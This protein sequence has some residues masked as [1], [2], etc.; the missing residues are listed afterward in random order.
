MHKLIIIDGNA[1]FHRA[2]HSMPPFH[3]S[4]GEVTNAIYGFLRMFFDLLKREKPEYV[5]VA[6]DRA[7]PT[8]RHEQYVEYKATRSAPPDDLYPQL[9][10]LKQILETMNITSFELDGFEA[11]DLIGTLT[12]QAE[13]EPD[14]Q[15]I[16]LTGDRDALQLVSE[17][18]QVMAPLSGITQV[19]MYTPAEVEKTFGIRPDQIIDYKAL[20]GDTS[21]NIPGIPGIGPRQAATLLQKYGTLENIYAHLNDLTTSQ[22]QKFETGRQLGEMSKKL[23]TIHCGA[24][25]TLNPQNLSPRID[26]TQ[27]AKLFEELEF[28][29]LLKK[30]EELHRAM[31]PGRPFPPHIDTVRGGIKAQHQSAAQNPSVA[32]AQPAIQQSLF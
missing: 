13:K 16:I 32:D 15:T 21:D 29:S 10:R 17:K 12:A 14:L 22:R 4:K 9:P 26:F 25:I 6:W 8:F 5:T 24:P 31:Q 7:A 1:I 3:T 11:D 28:H 27:T 20:C 30:L 2:Y 23:V 19:K 18:T